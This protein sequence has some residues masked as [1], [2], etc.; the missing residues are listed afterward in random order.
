[1][2]LTGMLIMAYNIF[3]TVAKGKAVEAAIPAPAAAH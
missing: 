1:M 3:R 2:F